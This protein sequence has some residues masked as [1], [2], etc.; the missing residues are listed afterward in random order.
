MHVQFSFIHGCNVILFPC[1]VSHN[2]WI[3]FHLSRSCSRKEM[4]TR[5][6]VFT[7]N[8]FCTVKLIWET[9]I[10]ECIIVTFFININQNQKNFVP[11]KKQWKLVF[12]VFTDVQWVLKIRSLFFLCRCRNTAY[13]RSYAI[14]PSKHCS[15]VNSSLQFS[16]LQFY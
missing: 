7:V 5:A 1:D 12:D 8:T 13:L 2:A 6:C 16:F 4:T 14:P 9:L 11:C 15:W 10:H 3:W